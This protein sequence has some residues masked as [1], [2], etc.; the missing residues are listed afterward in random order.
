MKSKRILSVGLILVLI[1]L[2]IVYY[3]GYRKKPDATPSKNKSSTTDSVT[4][5]DH[6]K[7][8]ADI[9]AKP[10]TNPED[11]SI[12][13]VEDFVKANSKN[14]ASFEF[15]EWSELAIEDGYWKVR[16]KY[17]GISSFNAEVTTNAW[18][19]I[20]GNK[21]VYTKIISKI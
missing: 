2:T 9:G 7:A 6:E 1:A 5:L 17:R 19:Y 3:A 20:K 10:E 12:R 11:G 18:F 15:L 4:L 13:I 8:P 16:C 21:V 14:P